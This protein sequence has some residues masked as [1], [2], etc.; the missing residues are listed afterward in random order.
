VA[1][2]LGLEVWSPLDV[3]VV[4]TGAAPEVRLSGHAARRADELGVTVRIS[5]THSKGMAA[6]VAMTE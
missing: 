5:L 6:A 1:K 4:P 3:E 2:A